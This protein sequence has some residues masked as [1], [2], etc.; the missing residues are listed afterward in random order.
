M[1]LF[2]Q[3]REMKVYYFVIGKNAS[4]SWECIFR[5]IF[6]PVQ[7]QQTCIDSKSII[8]NPRKRFEIYSK[9]TMNTLELCQWCLS[10]VFIVNFLHIPYFFLVFLLLTLESLNACREQGDTGSNVKIKQMT[11]LHVFKVDKYATD[12]KFTDT[13]LCIVIFNFEHFVVY[14]VKVLF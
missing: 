6:I 5:L 7:A 8:R 1:S 2:L 11:V 4:L 13:H 3:K 14:W 12:R 9:L 10:S